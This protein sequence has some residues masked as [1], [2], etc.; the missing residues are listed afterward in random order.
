MDNIKIFLSH[1]L[2]DKEVVLEIYHKLKKEGFKPW[3]DKEDLKIGEEWSKMIP[4]E[5][6]ESDYCMVFL[7][8][9]SVSK[10]G[11]VQK[12]F[13]IALEVLDNI[14]SGKVFVLPVKL[15]NCEVPEEFM[16]FHWINYYEEGGGDKLI[17]TLK[18]HS[19]FLSKGPSALDFAENSFE[20]IVEGANKGISNLK[21]SLLNV[22]EFILKEYDLLL[23]KD[24]S[25]IVKLLDHKRIP[26]FIEIETDRST[27]SFTD[28]SYDM[29]NR[30]EIMLGSIR[31]PDL[32]REGGSDFDRSLAVAKKNKN[33]ARLTGFVLKRAMS[34]FLKL[35]NEVMNYKFSKIPDGV[36][37]TDERTFINN[38]LKNFHYYNTEIMSSLMSHYEN[39]SLIGYVENIM[40]FDNVNLQLNAY[41]QESEVYLFMTNH[42]NSDQLIFL[43]LKIIEI[44]DSYVMFYYQKLKFLT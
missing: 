10:R 29:I 36:L 16:K 12:E 27:Y 32:N 37:N 33:V 18:E 31:Y 2:E 26:N 23:K 13:K 35:P 3:L 24:N 15:D 44:T 43:L 6:R 21:I 42:N 34:L 7:S 22:P 38:L 28:R 17:N 41:A 14:P 20:K 30:S 11:Y 25:G 39:M 40:K 4:K 19:E 5:I 9:N 1:A 8:K